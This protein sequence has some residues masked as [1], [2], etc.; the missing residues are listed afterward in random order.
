MVN[1]AVVFATKIKPSTPSTS[2]CKLEAPLPYVQVIGEET[3]TPVFGIMDTA[4]VL[5]S[6]SN[7]PSLSSSKSDTSGIESPSVSVHPLIVAFIA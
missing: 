6:A 4:Q 2:A 1:V 5:S 3:I 7:T